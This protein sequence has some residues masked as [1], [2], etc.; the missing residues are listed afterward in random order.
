MRFWRYEWAILR[1]TD[2]AHMFGGLGSHP[3]N[4][5]NVDDFGPL[6]KCGGGARALNPLS[7]WMAMDCGWVVDQP[8]L[9]SGAKK[10]VGTCTTGRVEY[11]LRFSKMKCGI[12]PCGEIGVGITN[13]N[14]PI[15]LRPVHLQ[16]HM[17]HAIQPAQV[18]ARGALTDTGPPDRSSSG[19]AAS[20]IWA[21]S[22]DT[23]VGGAIWTSA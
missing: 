13:E 4:L 2:S 6:G 11:A 8:P 17:H 21:E 18:S 15:R 22:I 16:S 9:V 1:N 3:Q 14:S 7:C 20:S 5:G 19:D 23:S 10:N 12:D